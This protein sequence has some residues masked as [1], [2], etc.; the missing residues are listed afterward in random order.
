LKDDTLRSRLLDAFGRRRPAKKTT[1]RA[2]TKTTGSD[3]EA[4]GWRAAAFAFATR[5]R[6]PTANGKPTTKRKGCHH[7]RRRG[8]PGRRA[9]TFMRSAAPRAWGILARRN[10]SY[11]LVALCMAGVLYAVANAQQNPRTSREF[12]VQPEVRGLPDDLLVI[13]PPKSF[14]VTV[15]GNAG[16]LRALPPDGPV[17]WLDA[18]AGSRGHEPFGTA[19]R[20]P[21]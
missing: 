13:A 21:P 3:E 10:L 19:L 17:A 12:I 18:T 6:A 15:S 2:G 9:V 14:L 11:K 4:N 5:R 8:P 16:A 7:D 20:P 1:T